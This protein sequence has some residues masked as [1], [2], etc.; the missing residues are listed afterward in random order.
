MKSCLRGK[1]QSPRLESVCFLANGREFKSGGREYLTAVCVPAFSYSL[2]V[3]SQVY[4]DTVIFMS[5]LL[6]KVVRALKAF[7]LLAGCLT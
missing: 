5:P 7:Q 1:Y 6:I 3:P 4:T 2:Q